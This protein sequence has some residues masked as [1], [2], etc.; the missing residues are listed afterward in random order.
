MRSLTG[1]IPWLGP[2]FSTPPS[3]QRHATFAS[4]INWSTTS[5]A[6]A[7]NFSVHRFRVYVIDYWNRTTRYMNGVS[8]HEKIL[9][10]SCLASLHQCQRLNALSLRPS[11]QMII[12]EVARLSGFRPDEEVT[13][14][15][16]LLE[17]WIRATVQY[18]YGQGPLQTISNRW[19]TFT[20]K[21]MGCFGKLKMVM[22]GTLVF[23]AC[24][25]VMWLVWLLSPLI[26]VLKWIL[27]SL[28]LLVTFLLPLGNPWWN[29]GVVFMF[30]MAFTMVLQQTLW[31]IEW[32]GRMMITQWD[33]GG[34]TDVRGR[35]ARNSKKTALDVKYSVQ[36]SQTWGINKTAD[37]VLL[38]FLWWVVLAEYYHCVIYKWIYIPIW[39]ASNT[40]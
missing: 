17:P 14:A 31:S 7:K 25:I 40:S 8:K 6:S 4:V 32:R 20:G 21:M 12:E 2:Y 35:G 27:R 23:L 16:L 5:I 15:A 18:R 3:V 37:F 1:Q 10:Q 29:L 11:R 33:I 36:M 34:P 9:Q 28:W 19:K 24:A 39:N 38:N 22:F 30:G 13:Y 26:N